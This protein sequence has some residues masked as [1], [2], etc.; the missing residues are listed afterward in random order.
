MNTRWGKLLFAALFMAPGFSV[1]SWA[2]PFDHCVVEIT[3]TCQIADPAMPWRREAPIT[4]RGFGIIIAPGEILTTEELVR[5]QVMVE[6]RTARRGDK[7]PARV[8]QADPQTGL[9]FLSY[10]SLQ[11]GITLAP[12][13]I[14]STI[15]S[16]GQ[17]TVL[18]FDQTGEIQSD[19]GSIEGWSLEALPESPSLVL[20]QRILSSLNTGARG[21]PVIVNETLAGLIVRSD[22]S[23]QTSYAIP[24]PLLR[25]FL[26]EAR[27]PAYRGVASAG[28]TWQ[29]LVD[30]V[31][32]T[33]FGLPWTVSGVEIIHVLPDSSADGIL[34]P[35]D[36]ILSFDGNLLDALGYY[37]DIDYGRILFPFIISGRHKPGDAIPVRLWRNH[38]ETNLTLRLTRRVDED[39]YI[40]D[41]LTQIQPEYIIE[42]G[43]I[44]RELGGDYF[45]A[46]GNKWILQAS[47][48]LVHL[49]FSQ[50]QYS[51]PPHEHVVILSGV[52]PD[53]INIGY[54]HYRDGVVTAV[55]GEPIH[56]LDDVFRIADRDNGLHRVSLLSVAQDIVLDPA[57]REA[58][59]QRITT[60]YRIPFLRYKQLSVSAP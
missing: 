10:T 13:A 49:F 36:I 34:K 12:L 59:H 37:D 8:V 33:F 55:N 58:A 42:S 31:R 45:R 16:T 50:S 46:F 41:N 40:P 57:E 52:I 6:F 5:H 51:H 26:E 28:F 35:G 22:S 15:A 7:I 1:R 24:S 48:R 18:Q 2:Q 39:S 60:Q 38:A 30:A 44:F 21:A 54:Q 9:A 53:K 56:N 3:A 14:S 19:S 20:Q 27:S 47:P 11:K 29:P 23:R 25:K 32:R 43:L 4:K 17:V